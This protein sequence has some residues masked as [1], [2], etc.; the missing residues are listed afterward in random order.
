MLKQRRT[1]A[2]SLPFLLPFSTPACSPF[3]PHGL[4]AK[5]KAREGVQKTKTS[6]HVQI[7]CFCFVFDDVSVSSKSMLL[8]FLSLFSKKD[9]EAG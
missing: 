8:L 9:K 6:L 2:S 4:R 5:N 1:P 3:H 7:C